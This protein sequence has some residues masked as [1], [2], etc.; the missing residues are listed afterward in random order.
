MSGIDVYQAVT[1]VELPNGSK[2]PCAHMAFPIGS[3]PS[4][5]WCVYYLDEMDGFAADNRLHARRNNWIVEHYWKDYDEGVERELEKAIE[6][7]FGAFRK[8]EEWV[9]DENC[10]ETAYYFAEIEKD[11]GT[12]DSE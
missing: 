8:T 9:S 4:L 11:S 5:P 3:A 7:A 12:F 6:D 1:S 2:M 10:V